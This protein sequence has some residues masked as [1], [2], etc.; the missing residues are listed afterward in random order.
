MVG[1]LAARRDRLGD[2]GD[3][4]VI[5]LDVG[6]GGD[7]FRDFVARGRS[8]RRRHAAGVDP[9]RRTSPD[10]HRKRRDASK[11]HSPSTALRSICR[12]AGGYIVLPGLRQ[13]P[14]VAEAALDAARACPA[15]G[16]RA[17]GAPAERR[18]CRAARRHAARA[19]RG[20]HEPARHR[21]ARRARDRGRAQLRPVLGCLPFRRVRARRPRRRGMGRRAPGPG[22][23]P[24]RPSRPTR[25][26][27]P[28]R[29]ASGGDQPWISRR[30]D[31][32]LDGKE[33]L[34][35]R[36]RFEAPDPNDE[37]MPVMRLLDDCLLT[38]EIEPP[39]RSP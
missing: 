36:P 24:R 30:P 13:R 10:L 33:T 19:L 26:A 31:Q 2:P 20:R 37:L 35:R 39:M 18:A 34:D 6:K 16:M 7:G 5:D 38:D 17:R 22:R 32:F 29:A 14:R 11:R 1:A 23:F 15:M 25:R 9:D 27:A 28:S 8:P 12:T 3:V 21:Q 4:V